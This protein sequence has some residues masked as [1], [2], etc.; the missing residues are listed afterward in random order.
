MPRLR[1][2]RMCETLNIHD[3]IDTHRVNG[4]HGILDI[5]GACDI[6][7]MHVIHGTMTPIAHDIRS[8]WNAWR[9]LVIPNIDGTRVGGA[10]LGSDVAGAI[11]A[12][13]AVDV[14]DAIGVVVVVVVMAAM[15]VMHVRG[16]MHIVD[17]I[18]VRYRRC[19]GC[20]RYQV[21]HGRHGCIILAA[22]TAWTLLTNKAAI[23]LLPWI[24]STTSNDS[25]DAHGI[26]S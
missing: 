22:A 19:H 4:V 20:H 24:I 16:A 8:P 10:S 18:C 13:G 26:H 14:M 9:V 15:A 1:L 17:A 5:H 6:H 12:M 25:H 11:D 23:T 3:I 21:F 2:G 7:G